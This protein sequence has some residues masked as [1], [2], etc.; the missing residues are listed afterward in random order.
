MDNLVALVAIAQSISS[1]EDPALP[2]VSLLL[3]EKIS[4]LSQEIERLKV[5]LRE[6]AR[7]SRGDPPD[8]KSRILF[9]A[10]EGE[11]TVSFQRDR[12]TM[13]SSPEE[14]SSALGAELFELL[15][16]K[17]VSYTPKRDF[18]SLVENLPKEKSSYLLENISI[19][20]ETPRVGFL[21]KNFS[22]P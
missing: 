18:L 16:D 12:V 11:V 7:A 17:R 21:K 19:S 1:P 20:E 5:L 4:D 2:G 14:I 22:S 10:P 6:R 3:S 8:Q 15:F 9:S 13:V